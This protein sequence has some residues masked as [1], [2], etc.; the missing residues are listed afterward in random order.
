MEKSGLKTTS[1]VLIN[2]VRNDARDTQLFLTKQKM[3]YR[4]VLLNT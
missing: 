1:Y 3:P 2:K 4:D